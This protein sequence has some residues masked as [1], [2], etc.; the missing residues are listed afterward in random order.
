[1]KELFENIG[2]IKEMTESHTRIDVIIY[3]LQQHYLKCNTFVKKVL[4][5]MSTSIESLDIDK[6]LDINKSGVILESKHTTFF[7]HVHEY[8]TT[9]GYVMDCLELFYIGG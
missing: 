5:R 7:N 9:L 4:S 2:F 6:C 1:M 3:Q 8:S